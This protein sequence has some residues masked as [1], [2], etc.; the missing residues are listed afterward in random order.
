MTTATLPAT[1]GTL[2]HP[3]QRLTAGVEMDVLPDNGY[4]LRY[5]RTAYSS[6]HQHGNY[7][8]DFR[9]T[10]VTIV[11]VE[12]NGDRTSNA[13]VSFTD[14]GGTQRETWV[15]HSF[16]VPRGTAQGVVTVEQKVEWLNEFMGHDIG[17]EDWPSSGTP[18]E[19]GEDDWR[20]WA[21]AGNTAVLARRTD[22]ESGSISAG[23]VWCEAAT[24]VSSFHFE[25]D[26]IDYLHNWFVEHRARIDE[27][28]A[29]LVPAGQ[30]LS[31]D[32]HAARVL[33]AGDLVAYEGTLYRVERTQHGIGDYVTLWTYEGSTRLPSI[34]VSRSVVRY[35]EPGV[36]RLRRKTNR[37]T[38]GELCVAGTEYVFDRTY[39][40]WDKA[41]YIRNVGADRALG[42]MCQSDFEPVL[43]ALPVRDVAGRVLR[44]KQTVYTA[45]G[46]VGLV[47]A[48][49]NHDDSTHADRIGRL[50]V[51]KRNTGA[52][53]DSYLPRDEVNF[54]QVGDPIIND[55]VTGLFVRNHDDE[56]LVVTVNDVEAQWRRQDCRY[57]GQHG[58]PKPGIE[59][60]V[61]TIEGVEYVQKAVVDKDIETMVRVLHKGSVEH[62]L[63]GVYDRV[64]AEADRRTDYIKMGPRY[65]TWDVEV[66]QTV[67]IRRLIRVE[68][69][70][71]EETA[72]SQARQIAGNYRPE[73]V[74]SSRR[75]ERTV[76]I[77]STT[78]TEWT[79]PATIVNS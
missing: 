10:T 21:T 72:R 13:C 43:A 50:K 7:S 59:N 28:L 62:S 71:D 26:T 9:P 5:W 46:Q 29:A 14:A 31:G 61:V 19:W 65:R 4:P 27:G 69:V 76:A 34:D 56:M 63:C 6:L 44:T 17:D 64:T 70:V 51:Y 23:R 79:G 38:Y 41:I 2:Q 49:D 12:R 73:T 58:A 52:W 75:G 66:E 74:T 30:I 8:G 18:S 25:N 40:V 11:R 39:S 78:N 15:H 77:R 32:P 33:E 16:L 1:V 37:S 45:D 20:A 55:G 35:M 48:E 42:Y 54:A 24:G 22:I 3:T 36:A 67:V 47:L 53:R 60:L 68:N 57:T